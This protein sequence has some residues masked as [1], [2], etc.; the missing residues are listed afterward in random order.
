M[1]SLQRITTE[2]VDVEDRIRLVG[3]VEDGSHVVIWLTRRLLERLLPVLLERLGSDS[4]EPHEDARQ[5]F[6]Q[7]MAEA[8]LVPQPAV[9]PQGETTWLAM[10]VDITSTD[11]AVGLTFRGEGRQAALT[12]PLIA[13]RQW[14]GILHA[15]YLR[16]E[17]AINAW[18]GWMR[19][20]AGVSACKPPSAV[21][22]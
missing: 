1:V 9:V 17:W 13:L 7:E 12:F 15:A 21:L 18:P 22:H 4:A 19:G 8:Q 6:I 10:S 11:E 16:A 20:D 2:Y 5:S 14:L 3:E